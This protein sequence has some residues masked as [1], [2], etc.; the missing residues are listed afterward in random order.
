MLWGSAGAV[1]TGV[2]FETGVEDMDC[3]GG[4]GLSGTGGTAFEALRINDLEA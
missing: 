2:S 1:G 4:E 3:G